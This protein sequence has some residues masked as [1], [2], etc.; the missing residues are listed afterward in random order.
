MTFRYTPPMPTGDRGDPLNAMNFVVGIDGI[1]SSAFLT[2]CGIEADVAV[3]D[4]RPGNDKVLG[5]RKHPARRNQQHCADTRY[6]QRLEFVEL[7]ATETR[8]KPGQPEKHVRDPAKRGRSRRR[9]FRE[10]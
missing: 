8:W 9:F 1:P 2:V 7:D 4:Y 5:V 10:P 3:I 6:H